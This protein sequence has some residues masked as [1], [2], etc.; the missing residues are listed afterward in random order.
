[1]HKVYW[2]LGL[3]QICRQCSQQNI[4]IS[5]EK[6]LLANSEQNIEFTENPGV[7]WQFYSNCFGFIGPTSCWNTSCRLSGAH[8]F[9][10]LEQ[11][12]TKSVKLTPSVHVLLSSL[13]SP[14]TFTKVDGSPGRHSG[15]VKD[16]DW[17]TRGTWFKSC[18]G[19]VFPAVL[20]PTVNWELVARHK[21]YMD[22][23]NGVVF[24]TCASGCE[25]YPL[26]PT[27]RRCICR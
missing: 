8:K 18:L 22:A 7:F 6:K 9:E 13:E 14:S 26:T 2:A 5:H 23:A 1:M 16:H 4:E 27:V 15:L 17:D 12:A 20:L 25:A 24:G 19:A 3:A 10:I 11:N 21:G